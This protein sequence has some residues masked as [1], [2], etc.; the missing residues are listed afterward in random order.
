MW[1]QSP[2]EEPNTDGVQFDLSHSICLNGSDAQFLS[3]EEV[4]LSTKTQVKKKTAAAVVVVADGERTKR[5]VSPSLMMF[6]QTMS[7]FTGVCC[8]AVCCVCTAHLK[9]LF[10]LF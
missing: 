7:L 5:Q 10:R 2:R 3:Q 4:V 8:C 6:L 1:N 9:I